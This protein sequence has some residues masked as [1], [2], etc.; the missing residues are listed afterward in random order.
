MELLGRL[1]KIFCEVFDDENLNVSLEMSTFDIDGWDSLT[2]VNLINVVE[3]NFN[4]RFTE[5]ERVKLRTVGDFCKIIEN[6]LS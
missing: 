3:L 5:N 1:N 4:L 2:H 6:K